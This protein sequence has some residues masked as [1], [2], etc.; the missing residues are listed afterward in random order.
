MGLVAKFVRRPVIRPSRQSAVVE[1]R[2]WAGMFPVRRRYA[3]RAEVRLQSGAA[4]KK[5]KAKTRDESLQTFVER[6]KQEFFFAGCR[7]LDA[8]EIQTAIKSGRNYQ[9]PMHRPDWTLHVFREQVL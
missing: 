9:H 8:K 6:L 2:N 3:W 4:V 1:E 5:I 7:H